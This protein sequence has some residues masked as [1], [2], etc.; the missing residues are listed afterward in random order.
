MHHLVAV[1]ATTDTGKLTYF[2]TRGRIFDS[3]DPT[4]LEQVVLRWAGKFK[5]PGKVISCRV[6]WSLGEAA[7]APYFYEALFDFASD[8]PQFGD[9]YASWRSRTAEEMEGQG[10]WIFSVGPYD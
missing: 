5:T 10:K 7:H 2:V 6:C 8:P 3:V 9:E 1:E 4:D